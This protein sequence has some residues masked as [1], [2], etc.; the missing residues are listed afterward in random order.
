[1]LFYHMLLQQLHLLL[2]WFKSLE[3][4][5]QY[6]IKVLKAFKLFL[7]KKLVEVVKKY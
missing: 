5:K 7:F 3:N 6:S 1:M 2:L 4:L